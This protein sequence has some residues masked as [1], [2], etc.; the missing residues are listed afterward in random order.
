MI[1]P[2]SGGGSRL[3]R[4]ATFRLLLVVIECGKT[5]PKVQSWFM[6]EGED[7]ELGTFLELPAR[8]GGNAR[9]SH[10]VDRLGGWPREPLSASVPARTM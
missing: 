9:A 8:S 1:D 10:P 2:V 4:G 5:H 7:E 3:I 6:P